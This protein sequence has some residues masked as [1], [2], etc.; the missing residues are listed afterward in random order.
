MKESRLYLNFFKQ[1]FIYFAIASLLFT[2]LGVLFQI[3]KPTEYKISRFMEILNTDEDISQK[4]SLV[5]E[6]VTFARSQNIKQ[7]L[8]INSDVTIFNNS[9]LTVNVDVSNSDRTKINSDLSKISQLLETKFFFSKVGADVE[10]Y[11]TA[12][13]FVGGLVG[14]ALGNLLVASFLL[15]FLYQRHF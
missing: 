8:E 4:I 11:K 6:A 12:N 13:Y 5:Q 2:S 15:T 1:Y 3:Q 10:S 14:F 7:Q 9:P